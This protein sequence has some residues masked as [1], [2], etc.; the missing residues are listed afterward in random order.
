[1]C[2]YDGILCI[3]LC[4]IYVCECMYVCL[5]ML[6]CVLCVHKYTVCKCVY[7]YLHVCIVY[8]YGCVYVCILVFMCGCTCICMHF[9][10]TRD[11]SHVSRRPRP[12]LDSCS[13]SADTPTDSKTDAQA[14]SEIRTVSCSVDQTTIRTQNHVISY[15]CLLLYYFL[16]YHCQ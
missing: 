9:S 15:E 2:T 3:C 1:M 4:C 7:L 6:V 11:Q 8:V 5:C 14:D 16:I 13:Q 12:Y 10:C